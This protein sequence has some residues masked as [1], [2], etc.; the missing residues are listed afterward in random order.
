MVRQGLL[1]HGWG[2]GGGLNGVLCLRTLIL[3]R[4]EW[5]G[6]LYRKLKHLCD[7]YE[8]QYCQIP[9]AI[10]WHCAKNLY[11]SRCTWTPQQEVLECCRVSFC[12]S[13]IIFCYLLSTERE[14]CFSQVTL[15]FTGTLLRQENNEFYF[16]KEA[17]QRAMFGSACQKRLFRSGIEIMSCIKSGPGSV[18]GIAIGYGLDGP[19]IESRWERDFPHMS[20]PALGP[21]QPPVQWAPGVSKGKERPE[22]VELY[23][24]F[25][26][27]AVQP[28]QSLSACTMVHFT[29][30]LTRIKNTNPCSQKERRF[31]RRHISHTACVMTSLYGTTDRKEAAGA[32]RCHD[33]AVGLLTG[34]NRYRGG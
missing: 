23:L 22:Q 7:L 11:F 15:L 24:Y 25:P 31:Y 21:T 9:I 12:F 26:L 4:Y 19:G 2:G 20:R 28:V 1:R 30:F 32:A 5:I 18:V 3:K 27:R 29:F 16:V 10:P 8:Q 14:Y 6:C 17:K 34:L 13:H 33:I